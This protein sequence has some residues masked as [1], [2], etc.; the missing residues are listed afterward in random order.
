VNSP[1]SDI[2]AATK[3]LDGNQA[4]TNQA[5]DRFRPSPEARG[6]FLRGDDNSFMTGIPAHRA[7]G[8]HDHISGQSGRTH[9]C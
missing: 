7:P 3:D 8:G 1:V 5:D 6:T 9:Q 2:D 4:I